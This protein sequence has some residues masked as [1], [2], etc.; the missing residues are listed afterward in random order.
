MSRSRKKIKSRPKNA[1]TKNSQS[2]SDDVV[3]Q[4][5]KLRI[6]T[7]REHKD[8]TPPKSINIRVLAVIGIII[9]GM[10]GVVV[11]TQFDLTGQNQNPY[12]T[13][14]GVTL[15]NSIGNFKQ[16]VNAVADFVGSKL[17]IVFVSGEYCPFC[18]IE[19]WSIVMALSQYGTFTNLKEITSSENSVPT[20]T[21]V[22]SS[23]TSDTIDFQPVEIAD[24]NNNNLQSMN[25]LQSNLF[26]KYN[27]KGYI[28]FLCLGGK[29]IQIGAGKPLNIQD[30]SGLSAS[31][32]HSQINAKSGDIYSQIYGESNIIIT[33][34]NG[35]LNSR[36]SS[37][38]ASTTISG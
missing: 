7:K 9:V 16:D 26:N 27:E 34:I 13:A 30:F 10:S 21:F 33:L 24:N 22:G 15:V 35:L 6:T 37:T 14:P 11:L 29:Y 2:N 31:T 23:Y 3:K 18:A 36:S 1:S 12:K 25:V 32:I 17:T 4:L 28:P 20:Y 5:D 38:T 19:R 8:V